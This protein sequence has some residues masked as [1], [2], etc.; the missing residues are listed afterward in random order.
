M[1][2]QSGMRRGNLRVSATGALVG[3]VGMVALLLF[4]QGPG[5]AA[6]PTPTSSTSES[7]IVS[8]SAAVSAEPQ[9]TTSPTTNATPSPVIAVGEP[10]PGVPEDLYDRY[11][12]TEWGD[13]GSVGTTAVRSLPDEEVLLDVRNGWV[14]SA[15]YQGA[16]LSPS[17]IRV[18][19]FEPFEISRTIQTDVWVR[20]AVVVGDVLFWTGPI[21]G[22]GD[23]PR[24]G[25]IWAVDLST[26]AAPVEVLPGGQ[27]LST[28]S[29]SSNAERTP[30]TVSQSGETISSTVGGELGARTDFI[31][32]NG[33][34]VRGTLDDIVVGVTDEVAITYT[35]GSQKHLTAISIDSG[36]EL[37]RYPTANDPDLLLY[38]SSVTLD[39]ELAF[40]YES[41]ARQILVLVD[42]SSG[43][44]REIGLTR[45]GGHQLQLIPS[46]ST[47]AH[48]AFATSPIFQDDL[49]DGSASISVLDLKTGELTENAFRID[50]P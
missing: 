11:W 32:V 48:L 17:D 4:I 18:R 9:A 7:S 41:S 20:R 36:N 39:A 16:G 28:F 21:A 23:E 46:L 44:N 50:L 12:Y 10:R 42:L 1:L 31:D 40:S 3:T 47:P 19:T 34:K 15:D 22:N 49:E 2:M 35:G 8:E 29:E 45:V 27:D 13:L 25:G 26:Q 38:T 24:D 5:G 37:W 30:F 14:V 33:L 43:H 6:S